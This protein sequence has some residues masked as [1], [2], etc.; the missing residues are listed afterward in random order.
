M[1]AAGATKVARWKRG[2]QQKIP[3]SADLTTLF[4]N[5]SLS[6]ASIA[7]KLGVHASTLPYYL[8]KR[9]CEYEGGAEV[10]YK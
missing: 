5:S 7:K 6:Q 3:E 9:R 2:S 8:K 1:A 10:V 4:L